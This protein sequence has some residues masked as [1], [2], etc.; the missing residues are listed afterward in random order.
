M[1]TLATLALILYLLPVAGFSQV[2]SQTS[3]V[4]LRLGSSI[5]NYDNSLRSVVSEYLRSGITSALR[6]TPLLEAPILPHLG[7]EF[8]PPNKT[9]FF[10]FRYQP[11]FSHFN[12]ETTLKTIENGNNYFSS[13]AHFSLVFQNNSYSL[14]CGKHFIPDSPVN[15]GIIGGMSINTLRTVFRQDYIQMK[16]AVGVVPGFFAGAELNFGQNTSPLNLRIYAQQHVGGAVELEENLIQADFTELSE[17]IAIRTRTPV[18]NFNW[19][20]LGLYLTLKLK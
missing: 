20:E 18:F 4:K 12:F 1:K 8:T 7:V 17:T 15:I 2:Q 6:Q 19:F 3:Q 16:S 11:L 10:Q 14:G 13:P 5:G 9:Y